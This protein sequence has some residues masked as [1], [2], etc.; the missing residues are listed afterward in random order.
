MTTNQW[1]GV[2]LIAT[3]FLDAI[4]GVVIPR[5][6][7]D[8]AQRRVMTVSLIGASVALVVLGLV[9]LMRGGARG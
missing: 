9:F 7:P 6:L 3:G 2:I 4:L 1:L 5:R 8:P